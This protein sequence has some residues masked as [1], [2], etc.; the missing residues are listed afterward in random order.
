[1]TDPHDFRAELTSIAQP[2]DRAMREE[3][4]RATRAATW[5]RAVP[6]ILIVPMLYL[7][8]CLAVRQ[9]G[10]DFELPW[11]MVALA[12][13]LPPAIYFVNASLPAPIEIAEKSALARVDDA[14]HLDDRM[15]TARE[16]LAVDQPTPNMRAAIAD[17]EAHAAAAREFATT[18]PAA[19]SQLT[20]GHWLWPAAAALI[21]VATFWLDVAPDAAPTSRAAGGTPP[22]A[23]A[24]TDD[25]VPPDADQPKATDL[26]QTPQPEVPRDPAATAHQRGDSGVTT[27]NRKKSRG[28]QGRGKSSQA[29]SSAGR[30][31]GE[32]QATDQAQPTKGAKKKPQKPKKDQ[33]AKNYRRKKKHRRQPQGDEKSMASSG[34]GKGRGSSRSPTASEWSSKDQS[35][36]DDEEELEDEDDVDDEDEESEARGGLQPSLRQRKPPVNRDLNI[37]FGGGKPPP[38]ANG[39]GGPGMPKKQRGVAQLV[40]G[41]PY[42]DQIAGQPNPGRTKVTQER[43]EPQPQPAPPVAAEL[44]PQ[45]SSAVGH[46]SKPILL[47][48]MQDLVRAYHL[49]NQPQKT[50]EPTRG[51]RVR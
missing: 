28:D 32:G 3:H 38:H 8:V 18:E 33:P 43:I 22:D 6:L 25:S 2:A 46:L 20:R 13:L 4:Q 36:A 9:E 14:L 31:A 23:I 19:A 51:E 21:I 37:G 39:R 10:I 40:L 44:R 27:K 42:P 49:A 15:T 16:F 30:S 48:W 1:M 45:R 24:S 34:Q 35:V 41:I 50:Q 7:M 17:A 11:W 12:S 26:R 29:E 47:P 5:P